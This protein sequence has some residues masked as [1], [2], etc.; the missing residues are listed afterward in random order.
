MVKACLEVGRTASDPKEW[1]RIR[2][3]KKRAFVNFER[4]DDVGVFELLAGEHKHKHKAF[5]FIPSNSSY[6]SINQ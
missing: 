4:M 1:R 5:F 2:S 6:Q 3:L